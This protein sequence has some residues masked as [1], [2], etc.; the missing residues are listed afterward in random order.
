M[1]DGLS[2]SD[3][4]NYSL[5]IDC[6]IPNTATIPVICGSVV[7]G[8]TVG[9]PNLKGFIAGDKHHTFCP[10]NTATARV[11]TCGSSFRTQLHINGPDIDITTSEF[12]D[13]CDIGDA[14][15]FDFQA[16]ECYDILVGGYFR[17]EGDYSLS[18]D[19]L[20]VIDLECGSNISSSTVG[21]NGGVQPHVFCSNQTGR[22]QAS[23]CG[24]NFQTRIDLN[25]TIFKNFVCP[26]PDDSAQAGCL[27]FNARCGGEMGEDGNCR[28]CSEVMKLPNMSFLPLCYWCCTV[29]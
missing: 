15:I 21:L 4:G 5:S 13:G 8:S 12:G 6:I 22:V 26:C 19:C 25:D 17:D 14:V 24:S 7:T 3:E 18:I 27:S 29:G 20:N 9:L 16:G 1:V 23:T 10:R 11:S 28:P 2:S